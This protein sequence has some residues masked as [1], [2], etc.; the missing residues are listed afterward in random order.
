MVKRF[1]TLDDFDF[2]GKTVLLRVD[3]NSPVDLDSGRVSD[4]SRIRVHVTTFEE[5]VGE[6]ARVVVLAHQGRKGDPDFISLRQHTEILGDILGMSVGFVDDVFG[7][8]A[9]TAIKNLKNGEILVLE[10]VR[11]T[12]EEKAKMPPE[13][14]VET[15]FVRSL[16]GVADYYV[17]DAFSA[18][19]RADASLVAFPQVLPAVAGRIMERDVKILDKVSKD[20]EKPA[21]Y[22]LGGLKLEDT[23]AVIRHVLGNDISDRVLVTGLVA[24]SYLLAKGYNLGEVNQSFIEK[25]GHLE[26][27]SS[28]KE[29]LAKFGDRIELPVDL[30][31]DNEG[32][33]IEI[34]LEDLPVEKP[35][36]DIGS[37]TIEKYSHILQEAKTIVLNGPS[38]VFEEENFAAGTKM[39]FEAVAKSQ[40]FSLVGGGHTTAALHRFKLETRISYSTVAGGA[41]ITYISGEK[42]PAIE[43]LKKSYE[44]YSK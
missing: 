37:R 44:K 6:G 19:H 14:L 3:F 43:A 12:A 8:K 23:F 41:F 29:I 5:L 4:D 28:A 16:S 10:N 21:V 15:D 7:E 35:I 1:Y 18:A 20:P 27:L 39:L 2:G 31:Y 26:Y 17:N 40:A 36:K 24:N 25:K 30:A 32:K 34:G 22:V 33:R 9:I 42:L 38:G 13:K 11:F